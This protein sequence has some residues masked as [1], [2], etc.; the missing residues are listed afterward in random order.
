MGFSGCNILTKMNDSNNTWIISGNIIDTGGGSVYFG[1]LI[2]GTKDLSAEWT[3]LKVFTNG[4]FD[5][6]AVTIVY[7]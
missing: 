2:G 7:Q 4:T 5:T 1:G 3:Q 6:G